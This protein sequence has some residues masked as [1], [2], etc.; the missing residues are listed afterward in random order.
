MP[1]KDK[2]QN[3]DVVRSKQ[4]II[5]GTEKMICQTKPQGWMVGFWDG[6]NLGWI[7]TYLGELG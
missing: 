5:F 4:K 6:T 3:F 7:P 2:K 1:L